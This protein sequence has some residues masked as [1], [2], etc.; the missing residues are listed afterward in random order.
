MEIEQLKNFLAVAQ[1]GS[2][3][4]VAD[5]KFISQRTVSKQMTNLE[6][7]LGI[8]LF[9]R[10]S[11]KITLTSAGYYFSQRAND[12]INQLNDSVDKLHE[13]TNNNLLNLRIGY[14]SP[15][16]GR[17]LV[18]HVHHYRK[19]NKDVPIRFH[20]SEAS[21]E[22]L[23]A[24]VTLGILD[25]AYI[26]DYGTHEHLV[27]TEL[28]SLVVARGE[29]VLGISEDHSLATAKELTAQDLVNQ[30]IL[31]YSNE[32]S[33][34]LQ[35]AFLATLPQDYHYNVQRVSTIEQMQTLVSLGQAIAFYPESLP[36][37]SNDHIVFRHLKTPAD[38]SSQQYAIRLIYRPDNNI[39]GLHH[40]RKYL[41]SSKK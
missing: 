35:S 3:Q 25:C 20:I 22:H 13:I 37:F 7:E 36:M 4:K 21:I 38:P 24:D 41:L 5:H 27:N 8:K 23:I 31:Y 1:L 32:S 33:T 30:K 40:F 9:F 26:L 29:M 19:T 15:F 39:N 10:G 2:F 17:L 18:S 14:F 12:L 11:N 34:Y 6:N 28:N 16:E